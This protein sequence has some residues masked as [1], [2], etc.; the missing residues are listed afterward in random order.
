MNDNGQTL[1]L[2]AQNGNIAYMSNL[3]EQ[4]LNPN[5]VGHFNFSYNNGRKNIN[6][7]TTQGLAAAYFALS[8]GL[9]E[10]MDMLL[11][12]GLDLDARRFVHTNP[13]EA[14]I[15]GGSIALLEKCLNNGAHVDVQNHYG[16]S[17]LYIAAD[18]NLSEA[19]NMLL[20]R[21]A[22]PN[23]QEK[24]LKWTALHK[25]AFHGNIAIVASLIKAK[26][27]VDLLTSDGDTPLHI[28]AWKGHAQVA[29]LLLDAGA[30]RNITRK[31]NQTALF[32][33]TAYQNR[34]VAMLLIEAGCN[35][36]CRDKQGRTPLHNVGTYN[37]TKL[38]S[39]LLKKG[40][41]IL[42]QNK[43]GDTPL[44][45][46]A[47]QGNTKMFDFFVK[48]GANIWIKGCSESTA[49]HDAVTEGH[50]DIVRSILRT[51][52]SKDQ[53][54]LKDKSEM[55]ALGCA[56]TADRLKIVRLLLKFGCN[57]CLFYRGT[58]RNCLL[59]WAAYN[60]SKLCLKHLL[61]AHLIDVDMKNSQGT[62]ALHVAA[63]KGNI[64]I[65]QI[66][67]N[68]G[69]DIS[70]TT[71][72]GDNVLH[73]A[74]IEGKGEVVKFLLERVFF[75]RINVNQENSNGSTPL[76]IAAEKCDLDSILVLIRAGAQPL[77]QNKASCSPLHYAAKQGKVVIA[78]AIMRPLN[79][80][81]RSDLIGRV[82]AEGWTALHVATTLK[83]YDFVKYLL[84]RGA[85][86]N[87]CGPNGCTPLHIAIHKDSTQLLSLFHRK[88]VDL[89][90]PLSDDGETIMHVAASAGA[91][92]ILQMM[93][94]HCPTQVYQT[95]QPDGVTPLI[96]A[97]SNG[98]EEAA[99]ELIKHGSSLGTE[100]SI[101]R[102]APLDFSAKSG[103]LNVTRLILK[104]GVDIHHVGLLNRT[105][106]HWAAISGDSDLVIELLRKGIDPYQ[107]DV[108][109]YSA[110]DFA[111]Q[112][113]NEEA[114]AVLTWWPS[115]FRPKQER[116]AIIICE[117]DLPE[118]FICPISKSL[119]KD[120]V[121]ASDGF[122]YERSQ[123]SSWLAQSG[124]SPITGKKLRNNELVPAVHLLV[125]MVKDSL[126][127]LYSD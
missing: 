78:K 29:K 107:K 75:P 52:P 64:E 73:L 79:A 114:A 76:S 85:N 105:A 35:I 51:R 61:E 8:N 57:P 108:Y 4:G 20:D 101:W 71:K 49:L 121:F 23:L 127:P 14:A 84:E 47:L 116:P 48:R 27:N 6:G 77:K 41:D 33:A 62:T 80:N 12:Y 45:L 60:G 7:K 118:R 1:L 126:D 120:P 119:M 113:K 94:T 104:H 44:H 5:Y 11:D 54:N 10:F 32:V 26:A 25:A 39:N 123:I 89:S 46:S 21:G 74:L 96:S 22:D 3:L 18:E 56:I 65:M 40:A 103:L 15:I 68:Y 125:E 53:L 13:L 59:H 92:N 83:H 106:L 16:K 63:M 81:Q 2:A 42:S 58:I 97:L 19:V 55:T 110:K 90:E 122:A 36:N 124:T 9:V 70:A 82:T 102:D 111:V 93:L 50:I 99:I 43:S 34:E 72:E 17:A 69:A 31:D 37:D 38:A 109:G 98:R 95:K 67:I 30:S 28:A 100:T 115:R 88:G 66:L 91:T 24:E 86:P 87:A 112:Q 117:E